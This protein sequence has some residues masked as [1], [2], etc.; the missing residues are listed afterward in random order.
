MFGCIPNL[1]TTYY[2]FSDMASQPPTHC[3]INSVMEQQQQLQKTTAKDFA[4]TQVCLQD[5]DI[6]QAIDELP[7][8]RKQHSECTTPHQTNVRH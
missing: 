6:R 4:F 5:G 1:R 7:Q 8:Q 3:E 2:L